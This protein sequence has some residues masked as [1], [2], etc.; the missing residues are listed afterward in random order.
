VQLDASYARSMFVDQE[1]LPS[2][3]VTDVEP[4]SLAYVTTLIVSRVEIQR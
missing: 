1:R 4:F 3:V 2:D